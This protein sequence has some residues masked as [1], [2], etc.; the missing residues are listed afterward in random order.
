MKEE[1]QLEFPDKPI[2]VEEMF[3][4]LSSFQSTKDFSATFKEKN[5]PLHIL[6]NNAGIGMVPHSQSLSPYLLQHLTSSSPAM[7]EDGYE[8]HFQVNHLSPMLLTLELL[9]IMVDTASHCGDTRIVFVSSL[10]HNDGVMDPDNMNGERSYSRVGFYSN[11]KLYNVS[12]FK[13]NSVD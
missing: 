3:L 1:V 7:T 8:A 9:P 5:L 12:V 10:R 4:D 11:F 13:Y 6:I 2:T